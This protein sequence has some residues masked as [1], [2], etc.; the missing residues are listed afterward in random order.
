MISKEG[1][2]LL[3]L[4]CFVPQ[5]MAQEQIKSKPPKQIMLRVA[6]HGASYDKVTRELFL[7][8]SDLASQSIKKSR[9]GKRVYIVTS[10][11]CGKRVFRGLDVLR[12]NNVSQA[13]VDTNLI[14]LDGQTGSLSWCEEFPVTVA[15]KVSGVGFQPLGVGMTFAPKVLK[16]GQIGLQYRF[17]H[18]NWC[19]KLPKGKTRGVK[20]PL[21][22][23][24]RAKLKKGASFVLLVSRAR[25]V[26]QD[27]NAALIKGKGL[28][29]TVRV[30]LVVV[31][32]PEIVQASK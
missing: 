9:S 22:L 4:T 15:G 28:K 23:Q 24:G 21:R 30:D 26:R 3:L 25:S 27:S 18:H 31:I 10:G 2:G 16:N 6:V 7:E 32:T 29:N 11:V 8:M 19:S 17:S 12:R 5:L 13:L 20:Q 14:A 1:F